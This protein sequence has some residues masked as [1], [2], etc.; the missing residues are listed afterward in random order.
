M[1]FDASWIAASAFGPGALP[2]AMASW[3][4]ARISGGSFASPTAAA[5]AAAAAGSTTGTAA[6]AGAA[7]GVAGAEASRPL[8]SS[9]C[10]W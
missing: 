6:A 10:S 1:Y 7:A 5:L 9:S 4:G 8:A 2:A 3:T